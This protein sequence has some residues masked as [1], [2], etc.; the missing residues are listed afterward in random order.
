[1]RL[2]WSHG[3]QEI[4]T[5]EEMIAAFDFKGL[6]KSPARFDMAKLEDLNAQYIRK[7]ESSDLI[8]HIKVLFG[9][10]DEGEML[11]RRFSVVGYDRLE[12]LMPALKERAKTLID[13][14]DAARFLIAVRPLEIDPKASKLLDDAAKARLAGLVPLLQSL[15]DWSAIGVEHVVREYGKSNDLKLGQ[16]AQPLRAAMTGTTVSPTIFDVIAALPKEEALARL[17]DAIS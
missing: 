9:D 2:G 1:V 11:D 13:L 14:I 4:F 16:I 17:D 7:T 6:G 5:Q 10:L 15:T 3:D 12:Q 8:R